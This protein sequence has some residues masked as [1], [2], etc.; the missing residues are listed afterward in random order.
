VNSQRGPGGPREESPI[1]NCEF[2]DHL[3]KVTNQTVDK[4][5]TLF[6]SNVYSP[7]SSL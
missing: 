7:Q 4:G 6:D 3:S 1:Y 5:E 2:Y